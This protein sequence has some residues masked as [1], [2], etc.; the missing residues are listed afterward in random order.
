[1]RIKKSYIIIGIVLITAFIV[2][3]LKEN[4]LKKEEVWLFSKKN[5]YE[6][7]IVDNWNTFKKEHEFSKNARI[8][9]FSMTLSNVGDFESV[10]FKLVDPSG[11]KYHIF[12]YQDCSTCPNLKDDEITVWTEKANKVGNYSDLLPADDFFAK[13]QEVNQHK[14]FTKETL[15]TLYLVRT[16]Q[17]SDQIKFPGEYFAL[18]GKELNQIEAPKE[19]SPLK[20]YNLQVLEN[21]GDNFISNEKTVNIIIGD[22][23]E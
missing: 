18:E 11:E 21:T 13:L 17:W 2:G 19:Q 14:I 16:R 22:K 5:V 6:T 3:L 15:N 12:N 10:K 9:E 1:M 7:N 20:G 4:D 23:E 8:E